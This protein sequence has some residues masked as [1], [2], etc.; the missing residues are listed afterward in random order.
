MP[1]ALK[2]IGPISVGNNANLNFLEYYR[3]NVITP[4]TTGAAVVSGTSQNFFVKPWDYVGTKTFPNY[5]AY[6]SQYYYAVDFPGCTTPGRVFVGQR[7]E[8]FRVNLGPIFDLVNF[9]PIDGASGFPGGINQSDSNNDLETN[10]IVSIALEVPISCIRGS[11]PVIGVWAA[12]RSIRSQRQKARLGN[13]LINELLIGLK[14]KDRWNRRRPSQDRLLLNY[15]YYPSFPSILNALFRTAVNSAL[16]TNFATIAPTN[17]P[18]RDLT[19]ALLT[20][21]PGINLLQD[22]STRYVEYLRL[23]TSIPPTSAGSQRSL[24]V[25]GGDLAGYPNGRRFGDDVIDIILR[26]AMGVL[27]H[28]NLGVCSPSQAP[29]GTAAFTDGAPTGASYFDTTWPYIR[30]PR[31]GNLN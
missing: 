4:T 19:A 12:S 20:G 6:A 5:T 8:S 30:T 24:G 13:P 27:C 25:I 17:Y 31:P 10:N 9:V 18:R 11:S 2:A 28:A 15:I 1:I 16:R 21:I 22:S 23:N 26:V 29:V 3:L 7:K 14:D